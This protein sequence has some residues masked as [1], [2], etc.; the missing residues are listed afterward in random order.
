MNIKSKNGS[1]TI[2]NLWIK[3]DVGLNNKLTEV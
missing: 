2:V 1:I 3:Y